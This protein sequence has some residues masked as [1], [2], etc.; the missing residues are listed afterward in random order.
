MVSSN[1]NFRV[2]KN[3][4]SLDAMYKKCDFAIGAPGFSQIERS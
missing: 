4:V 3:L 2:F 1:K